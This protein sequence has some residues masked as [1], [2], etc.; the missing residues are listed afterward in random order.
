VAGVF[1]VQEKQV[2]GFIAQR[3]NTHGLHTEQD[4]CAVLSSSPRI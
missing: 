4:S 2:A 1:H 3:K